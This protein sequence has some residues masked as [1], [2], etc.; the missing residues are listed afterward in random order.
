MQNSGDVLET[1][2]HVNFG[3][4]EFDCLG[5]WNGPDG[6]QY[7]AMLDKRPSRDGKP[8]YRCAVSSFME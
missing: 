4:T 1:C 8:Q 6:Q 5:H 7:L 3:I 2:I